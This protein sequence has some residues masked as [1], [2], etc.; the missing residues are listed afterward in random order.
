MAPAR[1]LI[2]GGTGEGAALA[3]RLASTAGLEV[4]TSVAGVTDS[5]AAGLP[6]QVRQGGFGGV[7]GLANYLQSQAIDLLVDTTH[8]FAARM[9]ANAAEAASRT[10]VPWLRLDRPG[11]T[12]QPGD[13]WTEVADAAEAAS[14]LSRFGPRVFLS[15][16]QGELEPFAELSDRWFLVRMVA[17]PRQPLPL[18]RAELIRARGPFAE[19]DELELLR[20]HAIDVVVSKNSGGAA[21]YGKIAAARHLGLPVVMIARPAP[22]EADTVTSV[23]G[24]Y[25]WVMARAGA[26]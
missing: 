7:E 19:A 18:P 4:I 25:D 24:A 13:R 5:A 2:L 21:T 6:G 1:V 22:P 26:A 11:W 17:P 8:P 15:V 20:R 10:G 23:A 3:R 12:P 16:G 14:A 9:T